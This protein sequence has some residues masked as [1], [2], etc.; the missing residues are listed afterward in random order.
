MIMIVI[1]NC[2]S[3]CHVIS[4]SLESIQ[5]HPSHNRSSPV[6]PSAEDSYQRPKPDLRLKQH[7]S[8]KIIWQRNG[9]PTQRRPELRD[10]SECKQEVN[11]TWFKD[12][13]IT[14]GKMTDT[15]EKRDYSEPVEPEQDDEEESYASPHYEVEKMIDRRQWIFGKF[16]VWQYLLRWRTWRP[17]LDT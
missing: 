16:R 17:K 5:Q 9:F 15:S 1:A 10:L 2:I 8:Q 3:D 12:S 4:N 6:R 7:P 14:M 13:G 11:D